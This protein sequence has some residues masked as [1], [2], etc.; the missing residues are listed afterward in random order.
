[1]LPDQV[2]EERTAAQDVAGGTAHSAQATDTFVLS[3]TS[4]RSA[5]QGA[6]VTPAQAML[7][8]D[9][10]SC[11]SRFPRGAGRHMRG[12]LLSTF[13]CSSGSQHGMGADNC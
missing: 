5:M 8:A 4:D 9:S 7:P 3:T 13:V 2:V 1:M 12:A 10:Q 11:R 6:L